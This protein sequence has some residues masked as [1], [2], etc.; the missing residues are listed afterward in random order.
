[1]K[2]VNLSTEIYSSK[3]Q[4]DVDIKSDSQ[5]SIKFS[6]TQGSETRTKDLN[7]TVRLINETQGIS[8]EAQILK[9]TSDNGNFTLKYSYPYLEDARKYDLQLIVED[10]DLDVTLKKRLESKYHYIDVTKPEYKKVDVSDV[11]KGKK[12]NIKLNVSDNNLE[13]V[14]NVSYEVEFPGNSKKFYLNRSNGLWKGSFTPPDSTGDYEGTLKATD[15][16]YNNK[17]LEE[18]FRVG[19]RQNF[20][21]RFEDPGGNLLPAD[22]ELKDPETGENIKK[23]DIAKSGK[24]SFDIYSGSYDVAV[25][26]QGNEITLKNAEINSSDPIKVGELTGSEAPSPKTKGKVMGIAVEQEMNPSSGQIRFNYSEYVDN[27]PSDESISDVEVG[28]CQ[29]INYTE[30]SCDGEWKKLNK[31]SF[32]TDVNSKTVNASVPGFSIYTLY[33]PEETNEKL[34]QIQE[35]VQ[36]TQSSVGGLSGNLSNLQEQLNQNDSS[37]SETGDSSGLNLGSNS[38]SA[39]IKPG[40]TKSVSLLLQNGNEDKQEYE[41]SISDALK[42]YVDLPEDQELQPGASTE[43]IIEISAPAGETPSSY[44]GTLNIE[45]DDSARQTP[46]N[47][48]ILPPDN[49]LLDISIE[50]VFETVEPGDTAQVEATFNNQGYSRNVD[51]TLNLELVNPD[52]NET[53]ATRETTL[54]VSTTL[55]RVID[56]KIPGDAPLNNYEVRGT[57][58]YSNLDIPQ[59]STSVA[60]L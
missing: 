46:T 49:E 59:V 60:K 29:D 47:V 54:A 8:S 24:Y 2:V 38:I 1:V 50:P 30:V 42:Q 26:T 21:G 28:R 20:T 57:A 25:K 32:T 44:S 5:G 3:S 14:R 56:V 6:V 35:E 37:S 7:F 16:A 43:V 33:F 22:I 52:T 51:V 4:E 45:G 19:E 31:T 40:E 23:L 11:Y 48:Q 13:E 27:I 58:R 36:Q 53:V 34:E 10:S 15:P 18:Y 12:V 55:T 39:S 17:T 9:K 41:F